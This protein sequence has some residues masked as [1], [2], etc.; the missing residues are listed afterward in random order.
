MNHLKMA[1]KP[2]YM[3]LVDLVVESYSPAMFDCQ[4]W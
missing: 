1:D 3:N 4:K 2:C